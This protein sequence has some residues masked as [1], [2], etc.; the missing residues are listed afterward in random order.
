M[1]TMNCYLDHKQ[2]DDDDDVCLNFYFVWIEKHL[3]NLIV[4][5]LLIDIQ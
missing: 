3:Q 2:C 5:Y 4:T 1:H